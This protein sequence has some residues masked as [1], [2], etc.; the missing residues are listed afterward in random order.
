MAVMVTSKYNIIDGKMNDYIAWM[1]ADDGLKLTRS[2]HGCQWLKQA[3]DTALNRT[4]IWSVWDTTEDF[5]AYVALRNKDFEA[6][7]V[8]MFIEESFDVEISPM[9][10]H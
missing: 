5:Q 6:V 2:Q 3:I 7:M 1:Q 9:T 4:V 8:S 10:N